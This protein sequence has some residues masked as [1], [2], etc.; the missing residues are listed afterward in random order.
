MSGRISDQDK[1][2][3]RSITYMG[4]RFLQDMRPVQL[5]ICE[6]AAMPYPCLATFRAGPSARGT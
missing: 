4:S 3:S 6:G 2:V 1:V 5:K